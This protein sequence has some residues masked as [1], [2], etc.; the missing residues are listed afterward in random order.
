MDRDLITVEL[1]QNEEEYYARFIRI[2]QSDNV[3]LVFY[4]EDDSM[5]W[6]QKLASGIGWEAPDGQ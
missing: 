5:E 1:E 3:A 2:T 4:D 6:A